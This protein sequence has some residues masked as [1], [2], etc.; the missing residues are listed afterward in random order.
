MKGVIAALLVISGAVVSAAQ[1]QTDK[2]PERPVRIVVPFAPGGATDV[3]A[4]LIAP[5]LAEEFNQQFVVDNR[6]GAG[7][8]IGVE[9]V[10]RA[11]P[12]GHT[13]LI[14]ASSYAS[15]AA[16]YKL[17]FDPL[18]GISPVTLITR[19]VFIFSVHPSVKA[20]NLK[21]LIA[22]AR[23][24]PDSITYGSSGTGGV[25]HLATELFK[26]MTGVSMV[27]V[28]FKG[29]GPALVALLGGQIQLYGGGPI[30][31]QPHIA[32]GKIRAL[33]ITSAQRSPALPDLP[34]VSE[35]V[36]GYEAI[37]WF[38]V[39]APRG[40]PKTIV[41]RLNQAVARALKNTQIQ[42]RLRENGMEAAHTTPEEFSRFIA[43]EIAKWTKVVKTGNIK[44]E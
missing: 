19:G 3:V 27:H 38:G 20:T 26:Q 36:P 14:G 13:I 30:V 39:W 16:L 23:A 31:L 35:T 42:E 44:V 15:N 25:P 17:S 33:A 37:T 28:P 29:D 43:T 2:W 4:R 1:G 41:S 22:L 11:Q 34:A 24:K 10:V 9:I 8:S 5:R 40:T 32:S 12:D 21:E 6:A 18:T 7:G